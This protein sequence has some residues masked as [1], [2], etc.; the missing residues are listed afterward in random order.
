[1]IGPS[2]DFPALDF[3]TKKGDAVSPI[4]HV[5][6]D[7]APTLLV[8][9]TR[10]RLVPIRHSTQIKSKFD[11]NKVPCELVTIEGAGHGFGGDAAE[12]ATKVSL[13]WFEKYLNP[14]AKK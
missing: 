8:H 13:E 11:E 6:A 5:T 1:M 14:A 12:Q 4:V 10:D 7:D 9:G 2:D 3:D